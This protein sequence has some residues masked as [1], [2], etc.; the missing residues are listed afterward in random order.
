MAEE[1]CLTNFDEGDE[2]EV[3][4]NQDVGENRQDMRD[5][6]YDGH[7]E[8][9]SVSANFGSEVEP[10]DEGSVADATE[11]VEDVCDP[12][13]KQGS[14]HEKGSEAKDWTEDGRSVDVELHSHVM[15]TAGV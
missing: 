2:D 6:V 15:G 8:D 5:Q 4:D 7:D 11:V 1:D 13:H 10:A 12:T 14:T 3:H 9:E